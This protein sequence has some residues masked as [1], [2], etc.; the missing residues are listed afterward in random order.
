M[1]TGTDLRHDLRRA[2][3]KIQ[4]FIIYRDSTQ[5]HSW[6]STSLITRDMPMTLTLHCALRS[7]ER[8][9]RC[10]VQYLASEGCESILYHTVAADGDQAWSQDRPRMKHE[11]NDTPRL[12]VGPSGHFLQRPQTARDTI[13]SSR[14]CA[15]EFTRTTFRN[16]NRHHTHELRG[17]KREK[18]LPL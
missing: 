11:K 9:K 12:F 5:S 3:I 6:A 10:T 2:I 17:L 15:R 4:R 1:S 18:Q 7:R 14:Y 13:F 8:T 16:Q